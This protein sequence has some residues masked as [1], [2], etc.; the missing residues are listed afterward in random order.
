MSISLTTSN[1]ALNQSIKSVMEDD[2]V[3][4]QEFRTIRDE[5]DSILNALTIAEP[6][7]AEKLQAFQKTADVLADDIQ[8]LAL[9]IRKS[10][11]DETLFGNIKK[12]LEYQLTY[13]V[14]AYASSIERYSILTT[15]VNTMADKAKQIKELNDARLKELQAAER[16]KAGDA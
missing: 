2:A 10:K 16:N 5:A 8:K 7:L 9:A 13:V 12:A 1:A 4:M 11:P 15:G 14:V 3:S 6:T